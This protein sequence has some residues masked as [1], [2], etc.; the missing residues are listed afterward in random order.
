MLHTLG[1]TF[2]PVST[3]ENIYPLLVPIGENSLHQGA[4][5]NTCRTHP[6]P[7]STRSPPPKM[8]I[9]CRFQLWST[10]C[11]R[12]YHAVVNKQL[13]FDFIDIIH[14]AHIRSR[15]PPGLHLRKC[16]SI[17]D[18]NCGAF[19]APGNTMQYKIND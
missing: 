15:S 16:L 13:K 11:T 19:P 12:E 10:P 1:A 3:S 8:F 7:L 5:C 2:H 17:A 14:V 4:P 18:S 9:H 6:E